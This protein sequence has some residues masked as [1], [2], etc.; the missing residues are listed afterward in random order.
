[1]TGPEMLALKQLI[2]KAR[3][4]QL[5]RTSFRVDK[6]LEGTYGRE[7]RLVSPRSFAQRGLDR[8][9]LRARALALVAEGLTVRE[10]AARTGVSKSM[11]AKW[12]ST[13]AG[14]VVIGTATPAAEGV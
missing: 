4:A 7:H 2:D 5:K 8:D 10:V 1:M 12:N 9:V 3:R 14:V 13:A 6:S 11:V